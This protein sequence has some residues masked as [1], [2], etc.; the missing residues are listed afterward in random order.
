MQP[1]LPSTPSLGSNSQPIQPGTQIPSPQLAK[2]FQGTYANS[3][4]GVE[5]TLPEGMPG[6]EM[7]SQ[8]VTELTIPALLGAGEIKI[9]LSNSPEASNLTAS[10]LHLQTDPSDCKLGSNTVTIG[11]K[12]G[13]TSNDPCNLIG[14]F[15][16]KLKHYHVDLGSS[17]TFDLYFIA[18][19]SV[20]DIS[21]PAFEELV[22]TVKFTK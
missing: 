22:K 6:M 10:S 19:T 2:N 17:K 21:L 15:P 1:T 12:V 7:Q 11:G 4:F 13:R 16:S 3:E 9:F 5:L 20:Y 18:P 8:G 14:V